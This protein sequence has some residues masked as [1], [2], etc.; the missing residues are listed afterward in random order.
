MNPNIILVL[1]NT[2]LIGCLYTQTEQS[3]WSILT[4]ILFI[5]VLFKVI[6]TLFESYIFIYILAVQAVLTWLVTPLLSYNLQNIA[7]FKK[8]YKLWVKFMPVK[9]DFFYEFM[10]PATLAML[11]GLWF[12]LRKPQ[13]ITDVQLPLVLREALKNSSTKPFFVL[14]G[15]GVIT[16]LLRPLLGGIG[17]LGFILYLFS[18]LMLIGGMYLYYSPDKR[19]GLYLF[20]AFFFRFIAAAAGG[21]FGELIFGLVC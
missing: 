10:F 14:I 15:I 9:Q 12:V 4:I 3:V 7:Y 18:D 13:K 21:M 6:Q 5:S 8:L 17:G 11:V 2:L 1:I 20:G 19:G 16:T